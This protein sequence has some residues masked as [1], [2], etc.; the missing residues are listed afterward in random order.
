MEKRIE[1]LENKFINSINNSDTQVIEDLIE[2]KKE[3][4]ELDKELVL[5]ALS[6]KDYRTII[7]IFKNY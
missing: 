3:Y 4:I 5:K 2:I 6:Y 1:S 7:M